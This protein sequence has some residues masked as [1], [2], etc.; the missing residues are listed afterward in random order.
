M[1]AVIEADSCQRDEQSYAALTPEKQNGPSF[2]ELKAV[3]DDCGSRAEDSRQI[4]HSPSFVS[5]QNREVL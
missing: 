5:T 3:G 2:G 4:S 1:E